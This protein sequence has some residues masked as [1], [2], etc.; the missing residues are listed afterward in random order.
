[1]SGASA[2]RHL[3]KVANG[4]IRRHGPARRCIYSNMAKAFARLKGAVRKTHAHPFQEGLRPSEIPPAS[5]VAEAALVPGSLNPK[6]P[7]TTTPEPDSPCLIIAQGHHHRG[8][9]GA[10]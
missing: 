7:Y 6:E 1:M 8:Q 3:D 2:A 5:L 10:G 9:N 4:N